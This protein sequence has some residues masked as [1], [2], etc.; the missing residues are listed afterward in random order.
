VLAVLFA[1]GIFGEKVIEMQS[2]RVVE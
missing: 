2:D 1:S